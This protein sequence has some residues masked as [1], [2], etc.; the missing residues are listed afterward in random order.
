[1]TACRY[2]VYEA[3]ATAADGVRGMLGLASNGLG[4]LDTVRLN[5]AG[6]ERRSSGRQLVVDGT[7]VVVE[8]AQE[9]ASWATAAGA[10]IAAIGLL[11]TARQLKLQ[12]RQHRL[13]LGGI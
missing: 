4:T 5:E 9:L 11:L 7:L 8:L 12:N 13:E 1:M 2:S 6:R 10:V 3:Y